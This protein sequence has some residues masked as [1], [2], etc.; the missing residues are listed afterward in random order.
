MYV[1]ADCYSCTCI[2]ALFCV[3]A[4]FNWRCGQHQ[5]TN[6]I[7]HKIT[8]I[9]YLFICFSLYINSGAVATTRSS[10]DDDEPVAYWLDDVICTGTENSLLECSHNGLESHDCKKNER[11]GVICQ[12]RCFGFDV[13]LCGL[14]HMVRSCM[15]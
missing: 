8:F 10:F 1:A 12:G 9:F 11:A 7:D 6:D 15:V 14:D 2:V 3:C 4:V 5:F 13:E